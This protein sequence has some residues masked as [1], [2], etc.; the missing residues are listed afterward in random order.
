MPTEFFVPTKQQ[1]NS[2]FANRLKERIEKISPHPITRHGEKKTF[3]FREL[4][5]SPYVFVRHDASGGPLQP[6]YDGPYQVIQRGTKSFTVKINNK[7]IIIS[8]DRLKPA[9]IVSDDIEQ[10]QLETSAGT[11]DTFI[12]LKTTST[13]NAE[14]AQQSEDDSRVH[15]TTRAGRKVRFPDRLQAGLR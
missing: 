7:N 6:P 3:V 13:Q 14:R 8:I 15:H 5:T 12:P 11:H 10:Q 1:P 2:E 9:F 4:E